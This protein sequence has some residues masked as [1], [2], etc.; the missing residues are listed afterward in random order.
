MSWRRGGKFENIFES[1][2]ESHCLPWVE[3]LQKYGKSNSGPMLQDYRVFDIDGTLK[4]TGGCQVKEEERVWTN[5]DDC[6]V[7]WWYDTWSEELY[8]W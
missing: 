7:V 3:T 4:L 2:C 5:M 8:S 6:L 1:C